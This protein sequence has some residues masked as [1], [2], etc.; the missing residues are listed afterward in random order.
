V[1]THSF[2][3]VSRAVIAPRPAGKRRLTL[4]GARKAFPGSGLAE[5]SRQVNCVV[6]QRASLTP[7]NGTLAWNTSKH[8]EDANSLYSRLSVIEPPTQV[9]FPAPDSG[10]KKFNSRL[11]AP[12]DL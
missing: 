9:A 4:I 1:P 12:T 5:L 6:R 7:S 3:A 11:V 8:L 10:H 2:D